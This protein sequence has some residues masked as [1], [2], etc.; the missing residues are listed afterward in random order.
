MKTITFC[1][2]PIKTVSEANCSQHWTVKAKRH[3]LQKRWIKTVFLKERP[4]IELPARVVITRIAPNELDIHD[5]LPMSLKYVV[6]AIAEQL[7]GNFVPGQ[8]DSD[9]RISWI[10]C[11]KRGKPKEYAVNIE[12]IYEIN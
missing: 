6:D 11:Q 10:Y 5:N 12:I 2:L 4:Q 3:R 8:A 1:K 7:T 9:K